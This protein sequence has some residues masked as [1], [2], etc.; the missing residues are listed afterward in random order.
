M[1]DGR[2]GRGTAGRSRAFYQVSYRNLGGA[3][4]DHVALIKQ[5]ADR[6]PYMDVARSEPRPAAMAQLMRCRRP[7]FLG[8]ARETSIRFCNSS[9]ASAFS[10]RRTSDPSLLCRNT[11]SPGRCLNGQVA[12]VDG[13]CGSG[14]P[15]R[16]VTGEE[17][18]ES[19]Y[20]LGLAQPTDGMN[21]DAL[22]PDRLRIRCL[23]EHWLG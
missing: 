3:F 19:G 22:T 18:S 21:R 4:E 7:P 1:V 15:G 5:M 9:L 2:D 10:S 11:L 16:L 6:Y 8:T 12:A 23:T 14:H 17:D 13:Q 20:V